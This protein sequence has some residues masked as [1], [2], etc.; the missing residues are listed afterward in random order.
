M[1][2]LMWSKPWQDVSD[3]G[4]RNAPSVRRLNGFLSHVDVG[5]Y[6]VHGDLEAYS[7]EWPR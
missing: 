7:C 1:L 6:V 3:R 5:D 2:A 4:L